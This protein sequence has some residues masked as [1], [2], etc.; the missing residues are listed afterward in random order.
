M[1]LLSVTCLKMKSLKQDWNLNIIFPLLIMSIV[2]VIPSRDRVH[3]QFHQSNFHVS[4]VCRQ[5]LYV[6]RE[7]SEVNFMVPNVFSCNF[8]T[9]QFNERCRF[10]T[11]VVKSSET[12][13]IPC[14]RALLCV[15]FWQCETINNFNTHSLFWLLIECRCNFKRET[16]NL[17]NIRKKKNSKTVS[18]LFPFSHF[19]AT[20]QDPYL[21]VVRRA[22]HN[23]SI[24]ALCTIRKYLTVTATQTG[25]AQTFSRT[26]A[27]RHASRKTIE[28][29]DVVSSTSIHR[30]CWSSIRRSCIR[31]CKSW[32]FMRTSLM[33]RSET[34][35]EKKKNQK[36]FEIK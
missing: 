20:C 34:V 5:M 23:S 12:S 3:V 32:A 18:S 26:N 21:N 2:Y 10:K 36:R 29:Y 28:W 33:G 13:A 11:F 30:R 8:L 25:D 35:W 22:N 7:C 16:N 6:G 14:V 9:F 17:R 15:L 19:N 31:L 24:K 27:S 4:K 1:L